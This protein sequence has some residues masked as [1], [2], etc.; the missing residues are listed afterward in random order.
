MSVMDIDAQAMPRDQKPLDGRH[1]VLVY[2]TEPFKSPMRFIG[3]VELE[4]WASSDALDTDWTAK[5][6]VVEK[7]GLAVNLTYGIMRARYRDGFDKEI[8][9]EPDTPCK[10]TIKLN[11]VGIELQPGQRLRLD[12]SSSDFPNFD[13]NHNTGK[14]FWSDS[15]LKVAKQTVFHNSEMPSRLLLPLVSKK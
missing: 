2:Q 15:E 9:V 8:L 5:L 6:V 7:S 10:Y 3:P 12:V 1:D 14:D 11:P 4:L 13:R